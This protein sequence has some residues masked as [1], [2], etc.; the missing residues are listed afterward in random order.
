MDEDRKD[1]RTPIMFSGR[2]IEQIDDWRHTQRIW[3]R[4]EAIRQLVQ[5]GLAGPTLPVS[6]G[7]TP[8]EHP[9]LPPEL[10]ARIKTYRATRPYLKTRAD[11]LR[12]LVA[13]GLDLADGRD[14]LLE[15]D[16]DTLAHIK[17][18][19]GQNSVA[20]TVTRMLR[21]AIGAYYARRDLQKDEAD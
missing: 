11:A 5:L 6:A 7:P 15:L 2:E 19:A 20:E 8:S 18:F 12:D 17:R 21:D 16:S 1:R 13:A 3:S 4:G 14:E 10:I 9:D